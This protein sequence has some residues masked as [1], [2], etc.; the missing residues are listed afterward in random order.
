[1]RTLQ[2]AEEGTQESSVELFPEEVPLPYLP[3]FIREEQTE[4]EDSGAGAGARR[5][6]AFHRVLELMDYDH[7]DEWI[8]EGTKEEGGLKKWL[9]ELGC[10]G[11]DHRRG[12]QPCQC[13]PPHEFS[14]TWGGTYDPGPGRGGS[15]SGNSLLSWVFPQTRSEKDF[16]TKRWLRSRVSSMPF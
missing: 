14:H 6:T 9:Y 15:C 4:Q 16:H 10:R 12:C 8:A 2:S 7:R 13:F 11:K 3:A 5:G 1:M